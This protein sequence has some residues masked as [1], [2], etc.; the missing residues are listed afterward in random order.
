MRCYQE[1]PDGGFR[2][3]EYEGPAEGMNEIPEKLQ[4]MFEPEDERGV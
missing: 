2:G 3:I 4:Y 1:T